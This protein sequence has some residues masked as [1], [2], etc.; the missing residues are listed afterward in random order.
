MILRYEAELVLDA[1]A[2][3]GES[4]RWDSRK[5]CLVWVD[6]HGEGVHVF[7]PATGSDLSEK[8]GAPVGAAALRGSGQY[9]VLLPGGL[10]S[11][12]PDSRPQ[13]IVPVSESAGRRFNDAACDPTG[14]LLAGT[15]STGV[16][17][18][19]QGRLYSIT[20]AGAVLLK[21][22]IGLPNGIDW[23]P[24]G[25]TLYFTDS[26]RREIG[27]FPYDSHTGRM[28]AQTGAVQVP[29]GLPDG[30]TV[31]ADG[32]IWVA[33]WSAG[34]VVCL[35]PQG[36]TVAS[37][38][39]PISAVTSCAFGGSD[40]SMLYITTMRHPDETGGL[41]PTAGGL[42]ACCVGATGRLPG[43]FAG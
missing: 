8:V 20:L 37:V 28:G 9:V 17:G 30:H 36:K 18:E 21:E 19:G 23:S 12:E 3:V 41:E 15:M 40:L 7:D 13:T 11:W 26:P 1:R 32:N 10:M 39:V 43:I 24:D 27:V 5:Q 16:G 29:E 38:V 22:R 25:R 2:E 42:F 31:D 34:R 4:P 35:T 6:I 14:R 33:L